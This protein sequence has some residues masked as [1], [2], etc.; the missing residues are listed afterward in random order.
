M[1]WAIGVASV[2]LLGLVLRAGLTTLGRAFV[3]HAAPAVL[4]VWSI[5]L[6]S[7]VS[8]CAILVWMQR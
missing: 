5:T 1:E 8:A 4:L 3:E 7:V 2:V 6:L